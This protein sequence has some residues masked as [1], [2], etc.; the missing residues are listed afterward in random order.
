LKNKERSGYAMNDKETSRYGRGINAGY[1]MTKNRL[2]L[3]LLFTSLAIAQN[4]KTN[5][6][7][8]GSEPP[9]GY[10]INSMLVIDEGCIKDVIRA[11]QAS[12]IERRKQV[13]DLVTYG[14]VEQLHGVYYGTARDTKT[15][16]LGPT[17][18]SKIYKILLILDG[19]LMNIVDPGWADKPDAFDAID[20]IG[21]VFEKDFHTLTKEQMINLIKESKQRN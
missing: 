4:E 12:G 13:S 2:G 16:T 3:I 21:W 6:K 5:P 10:V 19:D 7:G 18:R 17:K 1:K 11:W 9:S 20:K 8:S 15:V 14:C